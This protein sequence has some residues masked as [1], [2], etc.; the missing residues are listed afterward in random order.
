MMNQTLFPGST[1][2]QRPDEVPSRLAAS[3]IDAMFTPVKF[4]RKVQTTNRVG[5]CGVVDVLHQTVP[6]ESHQFPFKYRLDLRVP[7]G[8][9]THTCV[10]FKSTASAVGLQGRAPFFAGEASGC[11]EGHLFHYDLRC[12]P[13]TIAPCNPHF[14][15]PSR[16]TDRACV[17][18]VTT[19][20]ACTMLLL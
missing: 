18:A 16:V 10:D 1:T 15:Q 3:T 9:R 14:Y 2:L 6:T 13:R 19:S 20:Q 12:T 7:G 4:L 5:S 11:T 17:S 8:I